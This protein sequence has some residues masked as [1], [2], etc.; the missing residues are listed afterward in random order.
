MPTVTYQIIFYNLD[1]KEDSR[2]EFGCAEDAWEA[3]RTFAEPNSTDIYSRITQTAFDWKDYHEYFIASLTF[4][5][6]S[7]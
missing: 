7:N 3:F 6:G 5:A 1:G 4:W 2:D